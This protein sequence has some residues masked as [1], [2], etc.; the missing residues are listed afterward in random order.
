[1]D[2]LMLLNLT[3]DFSGI[4][5]CTLG[6]LYVILNSRIDRRTARTFILFFSCL[7]LF[8]ASN[9]AGQLMRARPGP[10]WRTALYVSNFLEFSFSILLAGIMTLY[11]LSIVDPDREKKAV[12]TAVAILLCAHFALL[13]LSQFTGLFYTIDPSNVY[14]RSRWYPLSYL[15]GALLLL[16]DMALLL[17]DRDRLNRKERIAFWIY[18]AV[19]FAAMVLQLF[20]Y[21]IYFVLFS[22]ILAALALFVFILDGQT[23]RYLR[24]E[25]QLAD[26]RV[27]ILLSQIRPHFIYNTL[28]SIYVLC[29][30]DPPRAMEVIQDFSAYLQSNFDAI[31]ATDLIIFADELRHAQAYLAVETLRYGNKLTVEYDTKHTAF[32]LPALTLQ[33]LVENAVK[34][35]VGRGHAPEHIAIR[36]RAEADC[37][38][39][40]VEDNGPG[41]DP[42]VQTDGV[43]VGIRNV[44][45]R[46]A[47]M[48]GGTLDIQSS[49]VYGTVVTV[50]V[51]NQGTA[52]SM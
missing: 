35:G 27:N 11:L 16:L 42:A 40:T 41:F 43:H 22:G 12:R 38:V 36:T 17:R 31:A 9:A 14:H 15:M 30:D 10:A 28:T 48:C 52:G 7:I 33:P 50:T 23:E 24:Q 4:G 5:L 29:R 6:L 3:I 34:Y 46:L 1:M 8:V 13:I 49:P 26:M 37:A 44:R 19:P 21:G 51:P 47:M 20:V 2:M 25:R 39:L 18:F 32:R 45:E